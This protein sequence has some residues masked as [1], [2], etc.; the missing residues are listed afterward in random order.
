MGS[1]MHYMVEYQY[2]RRLLSNRTFINPASRVDY[3]NRLITYNDT[4]F[5]NQ[6]RMDR[7][8]FIVLC[9]LLHNTGR[10]KTNGL[11]SIE[12]QV[13]S[14]DPV[15]K[16]C[17]DGRWKWFKN[18][19]WA[20]DGTY[21]KVHVSEVDKPRFRSR[22]CEIATNVLG[23]CSRDMMFTFV[24]PGWEGSA[25]DSRVLQ[26]ALS[27]PTGMRV[28]NGCYYLMDGGYT[29]GEGF[30]AP[31]RGTRYHLSEW[32]DDYA[33]INHEEYFNM[34]HSSARNVIER[35]FG[36]L[37]LRWAILRS[38]SFYPLKKHCKIIVACCLLHNLIRREMSV[39]PIGH[40]LSEIIEDE[41]DHDVI[42]KVS[43]S[44][45]WTTWRDNLASQMFNE[46]R[47]NRST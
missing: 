6:L 31:Y 29:N 15:P 8:T 22:K 45:E 26:D 11:V 42:G 27:R 43:S 24:F 34:K 36:L 1:D 19:L 28:P 17:N 2:N 37:K 40:E 23:A 44:P 21:I 20:L 12:E 7:R 14:P 35:C 41:V 13:F 3:I 18:C 16:N 4:E 30:L 47:G 39:D 10:L 46:W 33:P 38:P 5:I 25:S 9:E 32:R